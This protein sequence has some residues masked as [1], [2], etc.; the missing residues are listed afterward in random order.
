MDIPVVAKV[1]YN[2]RN[3]YNKIVKLCSSQEEAE[4][5]AKQLTIETGEKH[6]SGIII[7]DK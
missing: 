5:E 7:K 2:D 3:S 1:I 4:N 6:Y